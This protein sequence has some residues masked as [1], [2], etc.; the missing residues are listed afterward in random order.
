M[1]PRHGLLALALQLLAAL[2]ALAIPARPVESITSTKT[3]TGFTSDDSA[4]V[5][6]DWVAL[7]ETLFNDW[8]RIMGQIERDAPTPRAAQVRQNRM[9]CIA[10]VTF[11]DNPV[12][13][14]YNFDPEEWASADVGAGAITIHPRYLQETNATDRQG[15]LVHEI[16]HLCGLN[17]DTHL[18]CVGGMIAE[19]Y[20]ASVVYPRFN[21][22]AGG[23]G[24]N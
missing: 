3:V 22:Y 19:E 9:L 5:R 24:G 7:R 20:Y 1:R 14:G 10:R 17:H 15:T 8:E 4:R 6:E 11:S 12:R 13:Y 16:G 23:C 21:S 2:P 18:Q